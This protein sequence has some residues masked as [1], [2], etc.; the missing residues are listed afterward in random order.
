MIRP[1]FFSSLT[2]LYLGGLPWCM[3]FMI[4]WM[5]SSVR[6]FGPKQG[7]TRREL[8]LES[9][10]LRFSRFHWSWKNQPM[11]VYTMPALRAKM[12][13]AMARTRST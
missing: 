4:S 7:Q 8:W 5:S 11:R 10:K 2:I 12:M 6:F 3:M 9:L 13:A 1:F